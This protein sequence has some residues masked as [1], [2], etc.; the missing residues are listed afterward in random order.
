MDVEEG[1]GEFLEELV[2]Q[3]HCENVQIPGPEWPWSGAERQNDMERETGD[4][5]DEG[6]ED[7]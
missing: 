2:G 5:L 3:S 4:T 1:E 7:T 6:R